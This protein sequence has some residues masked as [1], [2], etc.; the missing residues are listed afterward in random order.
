MAEPH[1]F[2]VTVEASLDGEAHQWRFENHE[3]RTLIPERLAKASG[4]GTEI[5]GERT[6]ERTRQVTGR[7]EADPDKLYRVTARY[8]GTVE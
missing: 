2:D 4:L 7:V 8:P 5:A 1:S 3:G 6:L